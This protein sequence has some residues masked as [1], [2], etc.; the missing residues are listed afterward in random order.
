LYKDVMLKRRFPLARLAIAILGGVAITGSALPAQAPAASGDP[1]SPAYPNFGVGAWPPA[2]WRPY[3][4][5]S[6]FNK[7]IPPSPAL[8]PR[9]RQIVDRLLSSGGPAKE[10]AGSSGGEDFGKPIYWAR[11]TDPVFTVRGSDPVE[12]DRI[13]IPAGAQPANG[14]DGHMTIVEPDG[15]EYDF[16]RASAPSGGEV[17]VSTGR[18]T[19]IDGEGIGS[20]VVEARW[21]SL[22]GRVR[23]PEMQAGQINH[24]LMISVECTDGELQWPSINRGSR[25]GDPADAPSLGDRFQLAMSD[26]EIAALPVPAWKKTILRALARYGAYVGEQSGTW[27]LLGFEGAPTYTSFGYPDQMAVFAAS[28][29]IKSNGGAYYFDI[30]SSVDWHRLRVIDPGVSRSSPTGRA[31]SSLRL[32]RLSVKPRRARDRPRV[33]FRLSRAATVTLTLLRSS[34]ARG[35]RF[36][37]RG[38]FTVPGRAGLNRRRLPKRVNGKRLR[39]GR[40]R[41]VAVATDG[42]GARSA[43]KRAGFS[44]VRR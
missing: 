6:P 8:H 9:S 34:R 12:G 22:A 41:V 13:H 31:R 16:W 23:A 35:T 11:P 14:S 15:W 30:A 27:S 39:R 7:P 32:T 21:G 18:K 20:G 28:V 17:H 24:A 5:T 43:V 10:R 36:V 1:C 25:C 40:Y 44:L 2:C 3:A 4:D 29:G 26:G 33:R 42:T 37:G 19:R 38:S